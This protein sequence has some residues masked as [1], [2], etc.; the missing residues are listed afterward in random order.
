MTDLWLARDSDGEL[1]LYC[2]RPEWEDDDGQWW[3]DGAA[4]G[5]GN[6]VDGY[7]E[8]FGWITP[9]ECVRLKVVREDEQ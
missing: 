6:L 7:G 5:G 9:G 1:W 4:E 8:R 3:V 2:S